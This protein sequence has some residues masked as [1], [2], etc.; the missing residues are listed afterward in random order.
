MERETLLAMWDEFWS[1]GLWF[2]SWT[3]AVLDLTP[4]QACYKPQEHVHSIW[5]LV[6]HVVFWRAETLKTLAGEARAT[7]MQLE[8]MNFAEAER[9]TKEAWAQALSRLKESHDGMRTAI[10]DES[11]PLERMRYHLCHDSNHL[12]QILY[13][14]RL[15]GLPPVSH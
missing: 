9:P 13:I 15:L 8:R 2:G 11:K 7:P 3:E 4:E 14:R 6:N 5:Q 1:E 10:A 12:G